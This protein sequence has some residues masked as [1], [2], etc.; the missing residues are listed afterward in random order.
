MKDREGRIV[1][2]NIFKRKEERFK[3]RKRGKEEDDRD[4]A[5]NIKRWKKR[6]TMRAP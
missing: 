5:T 1:M 4:S 2:T 6:S 3:I